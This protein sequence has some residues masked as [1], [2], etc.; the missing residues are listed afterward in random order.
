MIV[1]KGL[2]T[3]GK[4]GTKQKEKNIKANNKKTKKIHIFASRGLAQASSTA[5]L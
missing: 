5:S 2:Y 1:V 3:E 4:M